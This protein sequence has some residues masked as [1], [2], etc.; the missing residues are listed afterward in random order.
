MCLELTGLAF[1]LAVKTEFARQPN[2]FKTAAFLVKKKKLA[3]PVLP[4]LL[5]LR[6]SWH[7]VSSVGG[8]LRK[9][10]LEDDDLETD[11]CHHHLLW[12]VSSRFRTELHLGF[13]KQEFNSHS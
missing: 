2:D 10:E 8:S 7:L 3:F 1:V 13:K 9:L 5:L 11:N 12:V 4:L 6:V